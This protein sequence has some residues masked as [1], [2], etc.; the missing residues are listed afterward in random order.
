MNVSSIGVIGAGVIG[1]GVAQ[2]CAEVG[3]DIILV[4]NSPNA[5]EKAR[6]VIRNGLRSS[7]LMRFSQTPIEATLQRISFSAELDSLRNVSFIIE[8]TTEDPQV[9]KELYRSLQTTTSDDCLFAANTSAVPISQ[10]ASYTKYPAQVIGVHFMNPVPLTAGVEVIR[11]HHTSERTLQITR[12]VL[13][14]MG[15]SC[16]VV[17]DSPG[18]V[19][20]RI[21]MLAVNEAISV[22]NDGVA[23]ADQI[24]EVFRTCFGHPMGPLETADLIGLDTVLNSLEVLAYNLG[25][26]YRPCFLLR[27]LVHA[28]DLGRKSGQGFFKYQTSL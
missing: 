26:R 14:R 21:L 2:Q 25:E 18:F 24:D 11:G 9:K 8:N 23:S 5:L 3:F 22:L 19:S 20:N 28:G 1:C 4:D 10:I 12:D 27:K 6:T 13:A 17:N 16:I 7:R 15:K